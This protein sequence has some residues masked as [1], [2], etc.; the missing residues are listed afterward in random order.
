MGGATSR[1]ST[2]FAFARQDWKETAKSRNA[3]KV[4]CFILRFWVFALVVKLDFEV[5]FECET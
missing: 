2:V 1:T 3:V 5:G 4:A